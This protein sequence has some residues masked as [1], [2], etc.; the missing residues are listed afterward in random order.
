M[1]GR[2]MRKETNSS[3][4]T[5]RTERNIANHLTNDIM[6]IELIKKIEPDRTWYYVKQDGYTISV[7]ADETEARQKYFDAV[8]IVRN[9][10]E[11]EVLASFD[12]LKS[13]PT[14]K[15]MLEP[16]EKICKE[17]E[18]DHPEIIGK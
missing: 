2:P 11:H 6:K 5:C 8:E 14:A 18:A 17:Y 15:D 10:P 12:S 13:I 1:D 3:F 16:I 7:H 4:R 9:P